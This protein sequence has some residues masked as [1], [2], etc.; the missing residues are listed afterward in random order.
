M[1][2]VSAGGGGGED[3][4]EVEEECYQQHEHGEGFCRV[5]AVGERL[6]GEKHLGKSGGE[7]KK[8]KGRETMGEGPRGRVDMMAVKSGGWRRL[9]L[10]KPGDSRRN[11]GWMSRVRSDDEDIARTVQGC[12]TARPPSCPHSV[13][14][15]L[16]QQAQR[17]NV[18]IC[19]AP[20]CISA[21]CCIPEPLSR[22]SDRR[23]F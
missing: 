15:R 8:V 10:L 2:L 4:D 20:A 1:G 5:S 14:R 23:H 6:T 7:R 3:G 16:R 13:L 11:G 18:W 17:A 22:G 19:A 9:K 21:P 12:F